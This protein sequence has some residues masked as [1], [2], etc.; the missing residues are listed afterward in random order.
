MTPAVFVSGLL[1]L[2][3]YFIY[4]P[5]K[6]VYMA[7]YAGSYA[8]A[9]VYVSTRIAARKGWKLLPVLPIVFLT[10]HLSYG[11]GYLKGV[12]DFLITRKHLSKTLDDIPITR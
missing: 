8:A 7:V 4:D 6:W 11:I 9:N 1:A 12:F 2:S 10:L 5:S 3:L